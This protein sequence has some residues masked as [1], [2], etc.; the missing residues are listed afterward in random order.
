MVHRFTNHSLDLVLHTWARVDSGGSGIILRFLLKI[1]ERI[2]RVW[3]RMDSRGLGDILRVLV[4]NE[5]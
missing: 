5:E 4:D 2:S 1:R 3:T